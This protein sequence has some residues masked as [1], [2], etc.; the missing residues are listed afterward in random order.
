MEWVEQLV[1]RSRKPWRQP[2]S[3]LAWLRRTPKSSSSKS[4]GRECSAC[5]GAAPHK[6]TG[7]AG[8]APGEAAVSPTPAPAEPADRARPPSPG[9]ARSASRKRSPATKLGRRHHDPSVGP[10]RLK[11]PVRTAP[12]RFVTKPARTAARTWARSPRRRAPPQAA[13][14]DHAAGDVGVETGSRTTLIRCSRLLVAQVG[15]VEHLRR[16]K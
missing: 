5:A 2:S 7:P 12:V 13:A 9:R 3:S 14:A 16:R 15:G 4:R 10:A 11:E 1:R 8:T 6:G